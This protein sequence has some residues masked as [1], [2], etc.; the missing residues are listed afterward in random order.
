MP[1]KKNCTMLF[2][3]DLIMLSVSIQGKFDFIV[4]SRAQP[5]LGVQVIHFDRRGTGLS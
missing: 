3:A 4:E 1:L 2:L 5:I